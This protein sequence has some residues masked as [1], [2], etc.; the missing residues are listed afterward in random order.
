[1]ADLIVLGGSAAVEKAAKDAGQNITVPFTLRPRRCQPG[2]DRCGELRR[3]GA[4]K[5]MASATTQKK[6]YSVPAE[7][8]LIDR[9][10]L[11]TLSAPEMTVLVGGLRVLGANTGG[12]KHG[13]FTDRVGPA[14]QRLLREPAGHEAMRGHRRQARRASTVATTARPATA[15]GPAP[16]WTSSSARNSQ[17]RAISEVYAQSRCQGEVREGL[18]EGLG[19]GDGTGSLR[20]RLSEGPMPRTVR[21]R[22]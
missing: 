4:R 5:P 21:A 12:S 17:L 11:L 7:E 15:S 13:V 10:Q 19:E 6:T 3:D 16:A 20:S 9:A 14:H 18:R 2:A 8:M 22:T 1:M